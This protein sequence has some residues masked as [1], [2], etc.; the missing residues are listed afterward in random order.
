MV[1]ECFMNVLWIYFWIKS[2]GVGLIFKRR[3]NNKKLND[4]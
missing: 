3:E 1:F 4:F 2:L